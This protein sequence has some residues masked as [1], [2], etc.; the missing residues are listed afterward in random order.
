METINGNSTT[1]AAYN[2]N[3]ALTKIPTFFVSRPSHAVWHRG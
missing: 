2:Y 3:E 1:L